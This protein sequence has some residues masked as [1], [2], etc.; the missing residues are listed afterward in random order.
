MNSASFR[1]QAQRPAGRG[2]GKLWRASLAFVLLAASAIRLQSISFGL[3]AITDMD[4]L[5]FEL[6]ALRMI[7]GGQLN[8]Q[9]F[10]HPATTTMY[11]LALIDVGV[12]GLGLA[13]GRFAS[14]A[15]FT[16]AIY[17]DPGILVLPHRTAIAI[18]AVLSIALAYLLA[19][20]LFDRPTGLATAAIL[21]LSPV[22]I[23]Y[24]QVVRSDMMAT[25]FM[26]G[27]MLGAL[28][29]ARSGTARGLTGTVICVALAITT[30]WP[31]S[32][33]FLALVGAVVQ[34]WRGGLLSGQQ[35]L[36]CLA[37][38]AIATLVAIVAISPFLV[39]EWK[40]VVANLH[41]EVQ[42]HHLG[43][44][45]GGL[46]KNALWYASGPFV[47]AL[48]IAGLALAA[49]GA[50]WA[51]SSRE[52]LAITLV[53]GLAMLLL[54]SSQNIVWERWILALV[55]LLAMLAGVAIVKL[56]AWAGTVLHNRAAPITTAVLLI[57][58]IV[59]LLI[60]SLAD[61]RE[62]MNDTRLMA[63]AWLRANAAPGSTIFVEHFAFDLV[64]SEF[65][66]IFPLGEL[67]CMDAR[68]L[69]EGRIDNS[70]IES[71]RGG[72]TN[73]D[74]GTVAPDRISTCRADYVVLSQYARYAAERE[75]FPREYANYHRLIAGGEIVAAFRP[76]RGLAGGWPVIILRYPAG[77]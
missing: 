6:G 61:G 41:G 5:M 19:A 54:A 4:E 70:L 45:G 60:E 39:I 31:F 43:A 49:I 25:T 63:S 62:R 34:R 32:L 42:P 27:A 2:T 20:R 23:V 64:D 1:S 48:G 46:F 38:S 8:P 15:D 21:A 16:A 13:T 10:G 14:V 68:L 51:V 29:Y 57:G 17:A 50:W 72:R 76:E 35:M 52:F 22:H 65:D 77:E 18:G 7:G 53:P 40:T 24:S 67:G 55:P 47:R 12:L 71:A 66:F 73:I 75:R 37:A 74:Y 58:V 56:S 36:V 3:P 11:L 30:K 33:A 9:W 69:L 26:L 59:P 44:T 28:A